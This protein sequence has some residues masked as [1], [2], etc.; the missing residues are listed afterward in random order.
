[1]IVS[2]RHGAWLLV[3]LARRAPDHGATR[4]LV[5]QPPDGLAPFS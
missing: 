5:G 1:M 2:C 3:S 4:L